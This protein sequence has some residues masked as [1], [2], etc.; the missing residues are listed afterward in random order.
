MSSGIQPDASVADFHADAPR[1]V[2]SVKSVLGQGQLDAIFSQR[3]VG[4][5]AGDDVLGFAVTLEMLLVDVI[6]HHPGRIA[7]LAADRENSLRGFP[8]E[9]SEANRERVDHRRRD[10]SRMLFAGHEL[11]GSHF[12]LGFGWIGPVGDGK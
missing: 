6:G 5:V 10:S 11:G 3:I 9:T 12:A 2:G 4:I 8:I 1:H 7:R